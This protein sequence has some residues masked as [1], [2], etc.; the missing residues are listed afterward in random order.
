MSVYLTAFK[1][2]SKSTNSSK[3]STLNSPR[4]TKPESSRYQ[5]TKKK[6]SHENQKKSTTA[7]NVWWLFSNRLGNS[8][9]IGDTSLISDN[10]I[11]FMLTSS[12]YGHVI[13]FYIQGKTQSF[14]SGISDNVSRQTTIIY[15]KKFFDF[16]AISGGIS[17]IGSNSR[18]NPKTAALFGSL[19][20]FK[21]DSWGIGSEFYS[22]NYLISVAKN[23]L[24]SQISPFI[25]KNVP[26][27]SLGLDVKLSLSASSTEV[28]TTYNNE[29]LFASEVLDYSSY[30]FEGSLALKSLQLIFSYWTG[31]EYT[32]VREKGLALRSLYNHYTE[33][34]LIEVKYTRKSSS[35]F[36]L[37]ISNEVFY[38]G[39]NLDPAEERVVKISW[40]LSM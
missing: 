38:E 28:N 13:D 14:N 20:V 32:T 22:S 3:R 8:S 17:Y 36:S 1:A 15:S 4:Y 19:E 33:G 7:K 26:L 23:I 25:Y 5:K 10:Y 39:I 24:S 40:G 37:G 29:V 35:Y 16:L 21:N 6:V 34:G 18:V 30:Q 12:I 9:F 31:V 2:L 27:K 11:G